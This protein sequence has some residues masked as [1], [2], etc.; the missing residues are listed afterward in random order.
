MLDSNKLE[1][2]DGEVTACSVETATFK[3]LHF[4]S[5][6]CFFGSDSFPTLNLNNCDS[7]HLAHLKV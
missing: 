6:S 3:Y 4:K 5:F 2:M 7:A 1:N